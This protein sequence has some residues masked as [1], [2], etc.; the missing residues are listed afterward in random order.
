MDVDR[1]IGYLPQALGDAG[2]RTAAVFGSVARGTHDRY[3]D[4]DMVVCSDGLAPEGF[5]SSL[6]AEYGRL[7][8]HPFSLTVEG[9]LS[10]QSG[11]Y[12]F[13][14]LTPFCKIDVS[15]HDADRFSDVIRNGS[16]FVTGPFKMI[17]CSPG[18][19][20]KRSVSDLDLVDL[21]RDVDL[22][23]WLLLAKV[24]LRGGQLD[25]GDREL[26]MSLTRKATQYLKAAGFSDLG[27]SVSTF[28]CVAQQG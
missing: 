2:F 4:V 13:E 24:H 3:S 21:P 7:L 27:N 17:M 15:F 1:L 12:W 26:L 23:K 18:D 11:R 20:G 9:K 14:R 28:G 5:L 22:Y 8:F 6:A 25:L 19:G 16:G 10:S